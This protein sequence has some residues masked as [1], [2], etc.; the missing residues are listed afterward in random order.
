ML[1]DMWRDRL[2]AQRGHKID[3][4]IPLVG[5]ERDRLRGVGMRLDQCQ[6]RRSP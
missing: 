6:R 4:V 1:R 5:T 3:A 2:V